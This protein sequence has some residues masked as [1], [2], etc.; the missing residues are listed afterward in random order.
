M[1]AHFQCC[2]AAIILLVGGL[3]SPGATITYVGS[4]LNAETNAAPTGWRDVMKS[5]PLDI[6]CDGR[7][8]TAGYFLV[9]PALTNGGALT[10]KQLPFYVASSTVGAGRNTGSWGGY[11]ILDDP[12]TPG[13]LLRAGTCFENATPV[14]ATNL[15]MSFTL[16]GHIPASFRVGLLLD[17]EDGS[18]AALTLLVQQAAGG[19][20]ASFSTSTGN[21]VP[22]WYFFDISGAVSN[23]TINV[24]LTPVSATV[25]TRMGALVWDTDPSS[26]VIDNGSV[27]NI[28]MTSAVISGVLSSG[29][30][31]THVLAYW[32]STDCGLSTNGWANMIDC[33][34]GGTGVFA[35]VL[36]GLSESSTYYYVFYS[37]NALGEDW[38]PAVSSFTTKLDVS[39]FARRMPICFPGYN[40][41]AT[42]TNFPV[43]LML[44]PDLTNGFSYNYLSSSNGNDLR[45]TDG[46]QTRFLNYEVSLWGSPSNSLFWVQVPLLTSNTTIWAL[47]GNNVLSG[48]R[49]AFTTNGSTWSDGGLAVWHLN[50]SGKPYVDSTGNGHDLAGAATPAMVT[51]GQIGN[52]QSFTG[53]QFMTNMVGPINLGSAFTLSAWVNSGG[54]LASQTILASRKI[55]GDTGFAFM[56][57]SWLSSNRAIVVEGGGAATSPTNLVTAGAWHHVAASVVTNG[58]VYVASLYVD[59]VRYVNGTSIGTVD[60]NRTVYMG[61]FS[62]GQARYTGLMDE[63]R[64]DSQARSSNWIWACWANTVSNG[65]FSSYGSIEAIPKTTRG[66][67]LM[68]R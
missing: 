37:T 38:A 41:G 59:G 32:G 21:M 15:H 61:S 39:S 57:N 62:D 55:G 44:G 28:T 68:V 46:D 40:L 34:S 33:G 30:T 51:T 66:T 16:G 45:F 5:K 24:S 27:S 53:S 8:G 13:G 60:P 19:G 64:I 23:D 3:S 10:R 4:H 25:A 56:V 2:A 31:N 52:A 17:N 47:M 65:T 43:L 18:E 9:A 35:A 14:G 11:A 7:Y 54:G 26:P 58:S 20:S 48:S 29:A 22:D 63:V 1:M 36:S 67:L 42:L 50:E 6:D 49:A 12:Q